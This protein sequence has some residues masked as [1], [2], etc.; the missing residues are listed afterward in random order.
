[1]PSTLHPSARGRR[2]ARTHLDS[3]ST[4]HC[5]MVQP[6]ACS[7][8]RRSMA[9][10]T[11]RQTLDLQVLGRGGKHSPSECQR[12]KTSM[13]TLDSASA[14][15]HGAAATLL[16]QSEL[17]GG[18]EAKTDIRFAGWCLVV[19]ITTLYRVPHAEDDHAHLD[20]L[21]PRTA[22]I[23]DH[24]ELHAGSGAKADTRPAG[25]WSRW[26]ALSILVPEAEDE[27]AHLE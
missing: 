16:D 13:Y 20:T 14:S 18:S 1:M 10:P 6:Q 8:S 7:I 26:Q 19:V 23:L 3:A 12:Q 21:P 25:A 24:S 17:H 15:H 4:S 2:R 27:H 5:T 11:P 22:S 9:A